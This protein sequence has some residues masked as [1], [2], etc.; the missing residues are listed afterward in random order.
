MYTETQGTLSVEQMWCLSYVEKKSV[1]LQCPLTCHAVCKSP[2]RLVSLKGQVE[3]RLM[4]SRKIHTPKRE[5]YNISSSGCD[6][7]YGR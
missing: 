1:R 6:L 2:H 4:E 7:Y 5:R 3:E